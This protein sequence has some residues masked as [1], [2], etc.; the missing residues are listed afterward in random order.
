MCR[1]CWKEF[2]NAQIDT[3]AVRQAAALIAKVYE[4]NCVGGGL[5]V[6]VDDFNIEGNDEGRIER[7]AGHDADYSPEQIAAEV[8]CAAALDALTLHERASALSLF[9]GFWA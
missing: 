3:P 7:F 8:E 5:H 4:F 1:T 9:D 6:V 2:D